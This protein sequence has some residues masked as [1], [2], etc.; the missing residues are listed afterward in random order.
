MVWVLDACGTSLHSIQPALPDLASAGDPR[1]LF[2]SHSHSWFYAR[3]GS[4]PATDG[5]QHARLQHQSPLHICTIT[6]H[7]LGVCSAAPSA[8]LQSIVTTT[9]VKGSVKPVVP[10]DVIAQLANLVNC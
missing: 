10:Q 1:C 5:K 4:P 8:R 3:P 7:T 6:L 2:A 9:R